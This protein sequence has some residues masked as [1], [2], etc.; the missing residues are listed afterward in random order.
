M[1]K[2]KPYTDR[3]WNM[4][5][6]VRDRVI[7]ADSE[8]ARLKMEAAEKYSGVTPLIQKPL[9]S[10]YVISQ[11]PLRIEDD[12]Y[13]VGNL[14]NKNFGGGSGSMWLMADIENTWPIEADGLHHAPV[15]DPFY[16]RQLLAISPE[17]LKT[18]REMM[19]KQMRSG[20]GFSFGDAWLPDGAEA[21]YALQASDYGIPG[22]PGAL[23]PPGHLTPGFQNILKKGYGAIRKQAQDWLDEREGRVMGDDMRKYVFYKAA[24]I[25]CDGAITLTRRY[26]ELAAEKAKEATTPEHK[27][28]L[29][30]MAAGLEWIAENPARTFWEACQQVL[31]YHL[32]L[33]VDNGPGVTSMG[34][35]DQNVWP[36]L[37]KELADG[38]TTLD[39]AQEL[40]DALFLKLNTFS[41]GGFGKMAQ[42]AGIGH[43]GQHTTIGG[44]I[45]ETGEDATNPVSYMV[46]ETIARMKLH[47]PTVSL[48][49]HKNTPDEIWSC[50]LE[51]SKIIGG[52][53]LFQND[54][55]IIPG[56]IK[57]LGFSIEDARD[58]S[59]IG[60]QEI[61]GSGND[62]PAPNGTAMSHNGIYWSIV[63]TMAINN[64]INPM[65]GA[66]SPEH[67]RSGYLY[68][69]NSIEEVRAAVEKLARWMLT[70]SAT[71]NN[72]AEYEQA[73]LYPFPNLSISTTGCME[74]GMD[75]SAGG[76]KYNSYGGT[77][78]GLAT[79]GDSLTA[80]KYMV[81]D[82][83]LATG[84]EFLDA[85]LANWDG[86]EPL[87]QR[88]ITE[89]PHYGNADPYAD[90]ELK[91]VVDLYY[92]LCTE[93]SN[94]RC[95]V[96]KGGMYGA[97]DHVPQGELTWATP[98]GRKTGT[99]IADAMSPVQGRDLNGPTS[100]FLSTT[101]FDHSRF[102]DGMAVNLRLHPT[103]LSRDDGVTKLR[104]MT[105]AFFEQGGME[106][107]YNVVD[108]AT[109][110]EAQANPEKHHNLVVRIAGYSAYFVEMTEAMQN[111]VISRAEHNF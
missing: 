45:P 88:V 37:K 40:V 52:L 103:A 72:Y 54:D 13:F 7:I 108:S 30:K 98:D 78:T 75:V 24:T 101:V 68:E 94:Q 110:R 5:E 59:L 84:K 9:Q 28:E 73:R 111:D 10:L 34:R 85:I 81:F 63:I 23:M 29:E 56:I 104:D 67:V 19:M 44:L 66:Q 97:A 102:M 105:K 60:C 3:V 32:F 46:L 76:A 80:L 77:A 74:K 107:Q 106:C 25:A 65:N 62:Y 51:T 20:G 53:P 15:D 71:L 11:M 17:E 21:F 93:F 95:S 61:V 39:E 99:P 86:Y 33:M 36:Y 89:A 109:L 26:A 92:Q 48:R 8:K 90:M 1:Y 2:F 87:R 18:L 35:F 55:V 6:K 70:W 27:E 82:K 96:Y 31:L 64:G 43:I 14:G 47:E 100:V 50:A 83:K 38:T 41:E 22:R 57:E 91:W 4:R 49:V 69:M 16:S 58:Y 79:V 42:T 12:D